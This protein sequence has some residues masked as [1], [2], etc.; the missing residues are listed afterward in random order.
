M[1]TRIISPYYTPPHLESWS[2]CGTRCPHNFTSPAA[3]L[4]RSCLHPWPCPA[5]SAFS[6]SWHPTSQP[7]VLQGWTSSQLWLR[8]LEDWLRT[9]SP[10]FGLSG[11]PLPRE[12]TPRTPPPASS[13]CFTGSLSPSGGGMHAFDC[14]ANP[15]SPPQWTV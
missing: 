5:R 12:S 6:A 10:P 13:N 7:A 9:P 15:L 3:H 2:S 14:I 4:A 1:Q 11:R 8:L